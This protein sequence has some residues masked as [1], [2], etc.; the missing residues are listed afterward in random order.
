MA[1]DERSEECSK[2]QVRQYLLLNAC[3]ML[4]LYFVPFELFLNQ[5]KNFKILGNF[6][7]T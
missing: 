3:N 1:H 5:S 7:D 4:F 2:K 6:Y